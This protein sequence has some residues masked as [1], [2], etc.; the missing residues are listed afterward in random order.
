MRDPGMRDWTFGRQSE[1]DNASR[2]FSEHFVPKGRCDNSPA[3]QRWGPP[4]SGAKSRRDDR[5]TAINERCK[6]EPSFVHPGLMSP[7]PPNPA[8]NR[9]AIAVCPS[10]SEE[11]RVGK[12]CRS[13]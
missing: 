8:M 9:W 5:G 1:K 11:R 10:R 2:K 4:P 6:N 7:A 13:R 12:E 3:F